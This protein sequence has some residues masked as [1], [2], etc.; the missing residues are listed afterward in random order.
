[1]D[2][3][4]GGIIRE[5]RTKGGKESGRREKRRERVEERDGVVCLEVGG[6]EM[7]REKEKEMEK[8]KERGDRVCVES[9]FSS[10]PSLPLPFSVPLPS[11]SKAIC[12]DVPQCKVRCVE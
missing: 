12:F 1:M 7:E 11:I 4:T 3:E 2:E 6:G 10:S 5:D 9:T 8:E